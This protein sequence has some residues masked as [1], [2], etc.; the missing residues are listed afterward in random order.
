VFFVREGGYSSYTLNLKGVNIIEKIKN[1][2]IILKCAQISYSRNYGVGCGD[3]YHLHGNTVDSRR[4][5]H[6]CL[7]S[8]YNSTSHNWRKLITIYNN[9]NNNNMTLY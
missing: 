9:N 8:P 5:N 7:S 1:M 2:D 6:R 4:P 3:F